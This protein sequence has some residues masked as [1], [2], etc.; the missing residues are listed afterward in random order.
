MKFKSNKN[1]T[2]H[3]LPRNFL[4]HFH[5]PRSPLNYQPAENSG[6]CP[7]LHARIEVM[8]PMGAETYL[9]LDASTFNGRSC[10]ARVDAHKQA[11]VGENIELP[12]LLLKAHLFDPESTNILV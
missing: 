9:Y 4:F 7:V 3:K 8:E 2:L 1:F 10:I 6:N 11:K 12:I 5:S